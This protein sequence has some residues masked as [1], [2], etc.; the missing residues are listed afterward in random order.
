MEAG[1]SSA[2]VRILRGTIQS[3][4][5]ARDLAFS[6]IMKNHHHNGPVSPDANSRTMIHES[7]ASRAYE[8]WEQAGRPDHQAET[9]W[10]QAEDQLMA[11]RQDL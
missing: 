4:H 5:R 11:E 7:I 9:H 2:F 3:R 8:L 10:L 1:R 6:L